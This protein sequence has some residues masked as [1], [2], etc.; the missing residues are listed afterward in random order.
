MLWNFVGPYTTSLWLLLMGTILIAAG[1]FYAVERAGALPG[2]KYPPLY[3]VLYD[4]MHKLSLMD[5]GVKPQTL[6][7][8]VLKVGYKWFWV[9][10]AGRCACS[11]LSL[12]RLSL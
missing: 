4:Y 3:L 11:G 5:S 6:A 12:S 1:L 7:G 10:T 2:M 9:L 8:H